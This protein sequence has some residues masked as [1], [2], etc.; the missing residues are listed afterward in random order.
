[1]NNKRYLIPL[2]LLPIVGCDLGSSEN[3][4]ITVTVDSTPQLCPPTL[5]YAT[6][7]NPSM[8]DSFGEYHAINAIIDFEYSF[9]TEY[10]LLLEVIEIDN[11][12]ADTYG[13][14]YR[15]LRTI[16][17]EQDPVGTTY[18]YEQVSLTNNAFVFVREGVYA[19]PPYEV[20]C[21]EDV[22]CDTLVDMANSGGVISVELTMTGGETPITVTNWN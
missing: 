7:C 1:M 8:V 9:G 21:A 22:D 19:L 17:E 16:R 5:D 10:E 15:V 4:K 18:L 3:E 13:A 2:L 20:L 14:E 6:L 11:P 12:P